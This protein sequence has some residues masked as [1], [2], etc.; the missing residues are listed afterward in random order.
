MRT[1]ILAIVLICLFLI[2]CTAYRLHYDIALVDVERPEEAK[3]RYGER[4]IIRLEEAY[5]KY[6]F[7]DE[8]IKILWIIHPTH[9]EFLMRNKTN[10]SIRILWD[11]GAYVDES[12]ISHRIIHGKVKFDDRTKSIPPGIVVRE[13]ILIAEVLPA[14]YITDS[15]LIG[16]RIN[17]LLPYEYKYFVRKKESDFKQFLE[18]SAEKVGKTIQL[19][20]PLQIEG[21]IHDYIF[22]FKINDVELAK[23]K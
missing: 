4:K 3:E 5:Y 2:C 19:L 18:D 12:S 22:I 21:V 20:L 1:K 9:L 13:G 14:D 16:S 11:E 10:H 6:A 7:E 23:E 8:M 15:K 17:P